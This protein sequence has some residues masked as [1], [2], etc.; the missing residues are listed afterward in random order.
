MRLMVARGIR[1]RG[2]R[3][4][5]SARDLASGD[6]GRGDGACG[7]FGFGRRARSRFELL[8]DRRDPLRV[9]RVEVA[10]R[11]AERCD[12]GAMLDTLPHYTNPAAAKRRQRWRCSSCSAPTRATFTFVSQVYEPGKNP[13]LSLARRGQVG[14]TSSAFWSEERKYQPPGVVFLSHCAPV[15]ASPGP[16]HTERSPALS[17]A[18][19]K[20]TLKGRRYDKSAAVLRG[21]GE[22]EEARDAAFPERDRLIILSGSAL[23]TVHVARGG[24]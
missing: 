9:R 5:M 16:V 3:P 15:D 8:T 23:H 11:D 21:P 13:T 10:R 24:V 2:T 6:Q 12:V 19:R 4:A 1:G 22:S 14:F 20:S 18:V 17:V 7:S